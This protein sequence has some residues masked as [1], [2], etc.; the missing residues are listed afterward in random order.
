M[1]LRFTL[2]AMGSLGV[3]SACTTTPPPEPQGPPPE[4]VIA[5]ALADADPYRAEVR[6]SELLARTD[7]NTLQRADALYHR[8]SLRRLG[9]DNRLGAVDDYTEMLTLAP[10]HAMADKAQLERD[11]A[12]DDLAA[13]Q[14]SL[15]RMLNLPAWFDTAWV[16]GRHEEAAARYQRS[17][18]SPTEQQ[19]YK[20]QARRFICGVDGAGGPVHRLGDERPDLDGLTWCQP[21]QLP[22]SDDVQLAEEEPVAA[23]TGS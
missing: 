14:A 12:E 16:M 18:I 13:L 6:L 4:S 17:G 20:L 15:Q 10:D 1:I 21:L 8:A 19:V 9:A 7:I 11:Y 3:I 2:A 5:Q 23:E 22:D